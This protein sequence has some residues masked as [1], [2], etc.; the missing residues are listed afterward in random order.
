MKELK[1]FSHT[2]AREFF[3]KEESYFNFD[4]PDYMVFEK[5][6]DK[7]SKKVKEKNLNDFFVVI[8]NDDG[9]TK[10]IQPCDIDDVNYTLLNN[11]DGKYAWRPF[12]LIHP[13]IYVIL[14]HKITTKENWELITKRFE[15]FSK[16]K[17]IICNSLPFESDTDYSDAAVAVM[18]WWQGIE[19]KSLEL[20][21]QFDYVTRP[22]I[23]LHKKG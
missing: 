14:V 21:L 1:N 22:K 12:Q 18:N 20:A 16:N 23:G 19:Q 11:K 6:L 15:A 4:L 17:N 3:L 10:K 7:I 2:E 13:V 5:L 9:K 8:T